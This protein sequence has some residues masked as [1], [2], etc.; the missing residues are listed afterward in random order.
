M[1]EWEL[2]AAVVIIV[3]MK[4]LEEIALGTADHMPTKWLRYND[5]TFEC[6]PHGPA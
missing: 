4:H 6:W 1:R 3:F 2:E 5:S